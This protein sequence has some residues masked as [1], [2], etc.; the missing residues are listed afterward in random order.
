NPPIDPLR[1][2]I[3]MS[4]LTQLG[5][6]GNVFELAADNAAQVMLNSPV[7]NQR[8]L[9]QLL[10]LPQFADAH[11]RIDLGFA[12][13]ESLP[14]ALR[15]LQREAAEAVRAGAVIL[16]LSD[17]WPRED[18]AV[19]PSLLATGAIHHHLVAEG[20]RCRCNL[21]VETGAARD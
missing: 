16:L 15:R 4:L 12:A 2:A 1:E 11:V 14:Q 17:R 5:P 7:L 21:I 20:L 6:E 13:G 10:A 8:K 18:E 3:V 19:V 9:R